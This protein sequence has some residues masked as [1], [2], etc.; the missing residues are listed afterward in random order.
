MDEQY[1]LFFKRFLKALKQKRLFNPK[2]HFSYVAP[3]MKVQEITR[4]ASTIGPNQ[5]MD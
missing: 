3:K 2:T 5:L 4:Q 1:K